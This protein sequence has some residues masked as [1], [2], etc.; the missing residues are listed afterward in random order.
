MKTIN[1]L[2]IDIK[3]INKYNIDE[4]TNF[5]NDLRVKIKFYDLHNLQEEKRIAEI[6]LDSMTY[7]LADYKQMY[8]DLIKLIKL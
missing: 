8:N 4:Y 6:K 2:L 7:I 1:E 3:I 5:I